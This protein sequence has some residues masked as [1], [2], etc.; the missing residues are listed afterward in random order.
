MR[1]K[2]LEVTSE[3]GQEGKGFNV[4]ILGTTGRPTGSVI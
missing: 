4:S 1:F 2:G 3:G